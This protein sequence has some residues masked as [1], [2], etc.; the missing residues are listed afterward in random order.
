MGPPDVK[1]VEGALENLRALHAEV[2]EQAGELA[3]RHPGRLRCG[4]GCAACCIERPAQSVRKGP[5]SI[6]VTRMPKGAS[7]STRASLSASRAYLV[8]E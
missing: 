2:D 8:V 4:R 1:A 7:S 3:A 5:A 6:A